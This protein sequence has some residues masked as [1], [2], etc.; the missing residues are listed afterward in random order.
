VALPVFPCRRSYYC[1]AI[2]FVRPTGWSALQTD[3]GLDFIDIETDGSF[4]HQ[5]I[6]NFP[7]IDHPANMTI[8][9]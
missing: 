3:R 8:M 7:C 2:L 6:E 9:C 1:L 5:V 4:A